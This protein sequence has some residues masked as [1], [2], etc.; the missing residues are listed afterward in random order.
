MD[1]QVSTFPKLMELGKGWL[2]TLAVTILP[3]AV[4]AARIVPANESHSLLE[5]S[6]CQP[7]WG[8]QEK[9]VLL[10]DRW[11]FPRELAT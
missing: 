7:G 4:T 1:F 3:S 5:S 6:L 8:G 9:I 11:I 2:D 10:S